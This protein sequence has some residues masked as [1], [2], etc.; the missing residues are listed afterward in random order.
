MRD[1]KGRWIMRM[2]ALVMMGLMLLGATAGCDMRDGAADKAVGNDAGGQGGGEKAARTPASG[3]KTMPPLTAEEKRIIQRKGTERAFTGRYW[4]HHEPGGYQCRQCGTLLYASDSKFRSDC[5]WPSFDDEIPGAVTRVPDADGQR[6]E[7]ICAACKG[8]LGHVFLG[9][10]FT[11]KN[12][13]HCVNSAS[14]VFVTRAKMAQVA[15][16]PAK[17]AVGR[18]IFAGGCFWGVEHFLEKVPGVVRVT[19][20][21]AGGKTAKPTYDDICTGRT[22]H[23]EVVEVVYDPARV[24]Y[25]ALAR[26]FFE[27]HDPT[28][29]NRQGPDVGDQY[30]SAVFYLD[31][32][33]KIAAEKL[34]ARLKANGYAVATTLEPATTFWPAEAYHQDYIR[35]HPTRHMCHMHVPRFDKKR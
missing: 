15:T 11:K 19:S 4:N 2:T 30:R 14:L 6:T 34:I 3:P 25:E 16:Q 28:Q 31:E 32:A 29:V 18:A 17:A 7:I 22:G 24:S 20:G 5:G 8:H 12:T 10:G 35:K 9:E 23:A 27:I 21:Y 1:V 13:R 26:R 33:Q